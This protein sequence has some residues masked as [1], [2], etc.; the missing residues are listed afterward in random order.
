MHSCFF[1]LKTKTVVR[2]LK[3]TCQAVFAAGTHKN[4]LMHRQTYFFFCLYFSLDPLT[5]SV[6]TV[7]L[8][9]QFLSRSLTPESVRNYLSAAKF[10]HVA[11]GHDF[12][13]LKEFCYATYSFSFSSEF[14]FS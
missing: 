9:C 5:A 8:Y 12:P 13:S 6:D 10:L 3:A 11:L 2:D 4:H 14:L 7:C 1:R